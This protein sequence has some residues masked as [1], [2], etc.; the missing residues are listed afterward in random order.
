MNKD[1]PK[2]FAVPINKSLKNNKD[3]FISD[4]EERNEE[5][6]G[7]DI[8]DINKIFNSKNHV[9]KTRVVIKTSKFTKEVDV[10]G[11]QN[12]SLLTLNGEVI[13][14]SEI[15]EIKKM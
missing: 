8:I 2:V 14:I 6:S 1:L 3:I 10:V 7:V 12:N 5:R 15:K 9:Y 11:M 4:E 13:P